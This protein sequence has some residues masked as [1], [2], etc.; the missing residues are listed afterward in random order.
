M[1][2]RRPDEGGDGLRSYLDTLVRS[3]NRK[4]TGADLAQ[5]AHFSRFHFDRLIRHAAG[6]TPVR[7]RRRILLERAAWHLAHTAERVTEIAAVAGYESAAA[8]SRAF[9]KAYG[10][11]P[12]TFRAGPGDLGAPSPNG[13]HYFPSTALALGESV[14]G[15]PIGLIERMLRHDSWVVGRLIDAAKDLLPDELS[16]PRPALHGDSIERALGAIVRARNDL[17]ISISGAGVPVS[18]G[19]LRDFRRAWMAQEH[20]LVDSFRRPAGHPKGMARQP[21]AH[22]IARSVA[23]YVITSS[24][25]RACALATFQAMGRLADLGHGDPIVWEQSG[26]PDTP[27]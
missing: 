22:A 3:L 9:R 4:A 10:L 25:S 24:V 7:L 5:S 26:S 18:G 16:S 13:I 15:T 17:A 21:D 14:E 19:A 20:L 27:T 6:E 12:S 11:T 2:A 8:F 23:S 1:T